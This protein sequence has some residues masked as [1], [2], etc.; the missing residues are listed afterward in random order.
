MIIQHSLFEPNSY[1]HGGNR[2][3]AQITEMLTT[4]DNDVLILGYNLPNRNS[5]FLQ[6][7]RYALFGMCTAVLH[8]KIFS[9][10]PTVSTVVNF[11]YFAR[12]LNAAIKS[13]EPKQVLL[14]WESTIPAMFPVVRKLSR[15][16]VV[17]IA[18]P[19]NVE[20]LSEAVSQ[21]NY[22]RSQM[23]R[24]LRFELNALSLAKRIFCISPHDTWLYCNWGLNA[25]TWAYQVSDFVAGKM[26]SIKKLR[27]ESIKDTLLIVGTSSNE[28]TKSGMKT[29]MDAYLIGKKNHRLSVVSSGMSANIGEE[30]PGIDFFPNLADEQ[31]NQILVRTQAIIVFQN[32]GTG[33]LTRIHEAHQMGIPVYG[34]ELSGRGYDMGG[35]VVPETIKDSF[36]EVEMFRISPRESEHAARTNEVQ[37]FIIGQL[38]QKAFLY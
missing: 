35:Y 16:G 12:Q 17:V 37:A 8:P 1:G 19:H 31:F 22:S 7:L 10:S 23:H 2:R 15:K 32:W 30:Y 29:L 36:P 14:I 9:L 3:T 26:S 25:S 18:F 4:F 33:Q 11:G 21:G 38:N 34:N 28:A 27:E 20:S 24:W 5:S 6:L 13:S